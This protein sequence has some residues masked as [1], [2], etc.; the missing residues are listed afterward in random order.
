MY[1]RILGSGPAGGRPGRGRSRRTE[2]SL[3]VRSATGA[4]LVDVTRDFAQQ[5][6]ALEALDLVLVTHPH[7]DASGGI[8][9]LDRWLRDGRNRRGFRAYPPHE[10][11]RHAIRKLSSKVCLISVSKLRAFASGQT[12]AARVASPYST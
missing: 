6:R 9:V 11:Q 8:H 3:L 4:I 5:A 1:V 2:S 12:E 7:R 10:L